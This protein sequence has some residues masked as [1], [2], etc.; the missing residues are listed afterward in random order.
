MKKNF[1]PGKLQKILLISF[2]LPFACVIIHYLV[3][4]YPALTDNYEKSDLMVVFGN[5][6]ETSGLP[7]ER[8]K[9]RL[10]KAVKLYNDKTAKKIVVS[11]AMGIEGFNERD[12][13]ISDRMQGLA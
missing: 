7:S 1:K 8:L 2:S 6:V 9:R 10:D 13:K 11:G 12:E 5:K 4:M 3:F